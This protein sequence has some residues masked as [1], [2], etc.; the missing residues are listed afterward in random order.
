MGVHPRGGN[1]TGHFRCPRCNTGYTRT[2]DFLVDKHGTVTPE[3][4]V[5][6]GVADTQ[7]GLSPTSVGRAQDFMGILHPSASESQKRNLTQMEQLGRDACSD[8]LEMALKDAR[9]DPDARFEDGNLILDV[10]IDGSW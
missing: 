1:L 10:A 8:M 9:A 7:C 2:T 6:Y 3:I 4:N 5:L